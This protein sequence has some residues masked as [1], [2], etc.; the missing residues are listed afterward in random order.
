MSELNRRFTKFWSFFKRLSVNFK[1]FFLE[2]V[3]A[4]SVPF[5]E[6]RTFSL[7]EYLNS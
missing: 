5:D 1:V 7:F 2:E 3:I 4:S 6:D